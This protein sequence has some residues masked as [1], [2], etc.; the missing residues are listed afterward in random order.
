MLVDDAR[1]ARRSAE[2]GRE[3]LGKPRELGRELLGGDAR[4]H[5]GDHRRPELSWLDVR[6]LTLA[7]D[8][9]HRLVRWE[10]E[11]VRH[12]ADDLLHGVGHEV[13]LADHRRVASEPAAPQPIA[14]HDRVLAV[15]RHREPPEHR[16]DAERGVHVVGGPG[17]RDALDAII[18][19]ERGGPAAEDE[20]AVEQ[21]RTFLVLEVELASEPEPLREIRSRGR[22][23]DRHQPVGVGKGQRLE[24]HR[25]HDAEHPGDGADR[26]PERDDGR[27]DEARGAH[28]PA[29]RVPQ[30]ANHVLDRSKALPVVESVV[31]HPHVA[32]RAARRP[33]GVGHA[34]SLRAQSL[35]L[36]VDVRA[37]LVVEIS[38][39]SA[40]EHQAFSGV[41][42]GSMTRAMDST[43]RFQR[44]VSTVSCFRP[45]VVSA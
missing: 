21:L 26:E 16:P 37:D 35:D 2:A 10:A 27:G 6:E 1:I 9:Q 29:P 24:N 36:E 44:P 7:R 4:L 33:L 25:V 20:D 22:P 14:D 5:A 17:H 15:L 13:P 3:L 41:G 30:I 28:E 32:E 45:D 12:H 39:R 42:P 18:R 23:L 40:A 43:R 19:A 11:L 38:L 31:R 8:P 34:H